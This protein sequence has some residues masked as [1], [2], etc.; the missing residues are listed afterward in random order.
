MFI[1]SSLELIASK[2]KSSLFLRTS[3]QDAAIQLALCYKIGFGVPKDCDKAKKWLSDTPLNDGDLER[4]IDSKKVEI[5]WSR[6]RDG[7]Y[8]HLLDQGHISYI[9]LPQYYRD[10]DLLV[11]AVENY[12]R[13]VKDTQEV[14]GEEHDL[15][16]ELITQLTHLLYVQGRWKKAEGLVVQVMDTRKRVLGQE[17]PDTLICMA[18][19]ASTYRNQGRWK[20]AEE[21]E[22]QVMETSLRVLGQ[23]HPDTLISMGNLASTYRNQGRWK[24]AEELE[25]QATET[26]L[27]VLGQ[28]HPS[29]LISM[30]NLASTYG[31]QG[32]FK[33]AEELEVQ[34]VETSRRVLG[35]EHPDTLLS[36]NNL[37]WTW[38]Q[39]DRNNEAVKLMVDCVEL[40]AKVLGVEHPHTR[41]ILITLYEWKREVRLLN[42]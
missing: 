1:V 31:K 13:E 23:E 26:S 10:K 2:S 30:A 29:T 5:I 4:W 9:D 22:V 39:Q 24:E 37:A 3:P 25:V 6:I 42:S 40:L 8:K 15:V 17:H 11:R 7:I 33:E 36:M 21:L 14:F 19:L 16:L 35:P 12:N 27:R 20:E 38:K 41:A 32:R 18:N 28:E 34:V